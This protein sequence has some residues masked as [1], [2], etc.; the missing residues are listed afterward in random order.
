MLSSTVEQAGERAIAII[1]LAL[2]PSGL[3]WFVYAMARRES[4]GQGQIDFENAS[5]LCEHICPLFDELGCEFNL[6]LW[7]CTAV[8]AMASLNRKWVS[9]FAWTLHCGR[10]CVMLLGGQL[11]DWLAGNIIKMDRKW[12]S[13]V[14]CLPLPPPK[15][16]PISRESFI[17]ARLF[18]DL[19][20]TGHTKP[21]ERAIHLAWLICLFVCCV[22]SFHWIDYKIGSMWQ[23]FLLL[24]NKHSFDRGRRHPR[25]WQGLILTSPRI[26][27]SIRSHRPRCCSCGTVFVLFPIINVLKQT[28]AR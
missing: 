24:S 16:I 13:F 3:G 18:L 23:C 25:R 28:L 5:P 7:L 10:G 4:G 11:A 1:P 20:S 22:T 15:S 17:S 14:W 19:E 8:V 27:L 12:S 26:C 2:A 6:E 9:V 21:S